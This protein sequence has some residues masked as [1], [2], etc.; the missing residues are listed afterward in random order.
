M[1][2]AVAAQHRATVPQVAVAWLLAQPGVTSVVLGARTPEQL[3]ANIAATELELTG[4]DLAQLDEVSALPP[5][6]PKWIQDM[7]AHLRLP[8]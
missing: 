2:R 8:A 5:F 7:F 1:A 6:Y 3:T 4:Q